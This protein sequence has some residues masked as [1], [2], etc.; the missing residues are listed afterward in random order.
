MRKIAIVTDCTADL[1]VELA[2]QRD[3]TVVPLYLIWGDEQLRA[4]STSPTRHSTPAWSRTRC[5]LTRHSP[6]RRIF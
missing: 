5:F 1:P 3:I 2:A 6:R 4:A